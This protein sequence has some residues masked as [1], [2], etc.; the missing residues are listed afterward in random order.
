MGE[1]GAGQR[2]GANKTGSG[3]RKLKE[4]AYLSGAFHYRGVPMRVR[5]AF[6]ILF[7]KLS[8]YL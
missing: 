5:I 1:G 2:R 8:S 6:L 4:P 3:I 7:L